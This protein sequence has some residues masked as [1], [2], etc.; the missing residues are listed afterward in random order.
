MTLDQP[1]D[2]VIGDIFE[3]YFAW[4]G[5]TGLKSRLDLNYQSINC[6]S[7]RFGGVL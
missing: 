7:S 5:G 4:F 3:K 2:T 1:I 6:R